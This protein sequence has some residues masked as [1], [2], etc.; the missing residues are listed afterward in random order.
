LNTVIQNR[1]TVFAVVL[2]GC[3]PCKNL[4]EQWKTSGITETEAGVQII[5]LAAVPPDEM[6]LGPLSEYAAAFPVYFI[7]FPELDTHCG[8][9]SFPSI[10]GVTADNTVGFVANAYV[11]RLDREFFEKYL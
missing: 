9:S 2:P 6:D 4:L 1:R 10:M 8:I 11:Q 7:E 5:M 3:D